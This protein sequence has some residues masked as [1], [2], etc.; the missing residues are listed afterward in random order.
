[1]GDS[2]V[3]FRVL[4]YDIGLKELLIVV[5]IVLL[6]L[7]IWDPS[8]KRS[9]GGDGKSD[10]SVGLRR[11]QAMSSTQNLVDLSKDDRILHPT[12]FRPFKVI[13]RKE[14]S[15]NT[16]LVTLEIPEKDRDLGLKIGRH[17]SVKADINGSKVIRAYTPTSHIDAKGYFELLVKKYNDG[18]LSNYIWNCKVGSQ[19]EVRGP[20]GR[21]KYEKNQYKKIGLI[22]AGSG[23]TP[24]LQVIR[25]VLETPHGVGDTTKFVLFFQ[26]RTEKDILMRNVIEDL[27]IK[28]KDR[29]EVV[30]FLSNAS[31]RNWG[32]DYISKGTSSKNLQELVK[33]DKGA[34]HV[35][36]YI[37]QST[38]R[39]YMRY[40]VCPMVG[41]C[42][43]SGF[44]DAMKVM[45]LDEGHDGDT[46]VYVW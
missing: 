29:L 27:A 25:S 10:I 1:M 43:P 42:G 9:G 34:H 39:S 17:V 2:T 15:Y 18:K 5:I 40:D 3:F 31:D 44:N 45:L 32:I 33:S 7:L 37:N 13:R 24:C 6:P 26:N 38:I 11:E 46:S 41:I 8:S 4:E 23:L 20:V 12:E 28:Y 30:F 36:G 14:E 22:C 19:I 16:I 21:Y 35:R